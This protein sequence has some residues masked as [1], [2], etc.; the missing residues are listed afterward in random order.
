MTQDLLQS[1]ARGAGEWQDGGG[2]RGPQ[3]SRRGVETTRQTRTSRAEKEGDAHCRCSELGLVYV[4]ESSG[5]GVADN[6]DR[7]VCLWL[8][9]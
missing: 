1:M 6:Y 4:A 7:A 2:K 3:V 8:V 9:L 5:G